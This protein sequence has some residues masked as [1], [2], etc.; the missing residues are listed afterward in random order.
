MT[1]RWTDPAWRDATLAWAVERLEG[2]GHRVTGGI[3]QPH[4]RPWS[5]VFRIPA[6]AGPFWCKASAPGPGYEG[7]LLDAFGDW[8]IRGAMLPVATDP[9][10]ALILFADGG[11]TMRATRPDGTGDRDLDAWARILRGYAALQRSTEARAD[12]LLAL[13]VPDGRPE[14]LAALLEGL[15]GDAALWDRAD[16]EDG[17]AAAEARRRLPGLLPVVAR[18]AGD[19]AASGIPATIQHDDLHGGNVFVGRD[20]DRIF[21][22]GDASVAHPFGTLTSTMNSIEYHAGLDQHGSE[23]IRLRDIYL[24]AW[25]DIAAPDVLAAAAERARLLGA[26]SRAASWRRALV[27][28]S[29]D[30]MDGHGGAPAAWLVELVDRL[31][32]LGRV[33]PPPARA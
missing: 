23:L 1:G 11:P 7:P 12:D 6:D 9:G 17:A 13:G 21:D 20:G 22:W 16:E 27:G 19:L 4:R 5:T 15:G 31:D 33:E 28:L 24:E 14:R 18:M 2:L 25:S 26:I 3:T 30:E 10:R 32:R 8:G 29:P